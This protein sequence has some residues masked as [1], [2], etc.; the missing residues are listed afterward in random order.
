[1]GGSGAQS[2]AVSEN[3][4]IPLPTPYGV[5][6]KGSLR[7]MFQDIPKWNIECLCGGEKQSSGRYGLVVRGGEGSLRSVVRRKGRTVTN[8][9]SKDCRGQGASR[10]GNSRTANKVNKTTEQ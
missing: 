1:M 10:A 4:G 2:T 3:F 9:Q 8:A 6:V 5:L 7:Q